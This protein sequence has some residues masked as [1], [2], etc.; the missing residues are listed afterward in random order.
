MTEEKP[1]TQ[2]DAEPPPPEKPPKPEAGWRTD[3]KQE[4]AAENE[5]KG[6]VR[7]TDESAHA[8]I[9]DQHQISRLEFVRR[10][11][12]AKPWV[13]RVFV[14]S[15]GEL[16]AF[17]R[18]KQPTTGE[19]LWGGFHSMYEVDLSLRRLTLEITLPSTGDA[20]VFRAEVDLQWR[21]E[22]PELVVR[23]GITDIRKVVI[24]LLLDRLRQV[25]RFRR[26]DEVEA[27]ENAANGSFGHKWLAD[28][29]GL[30]TQVL[31][32]L[33]MDKQKEHNVRL[34][35]EVEVFKT[36]IKGGDLDQFALQLAQNPQEVAPVVEALFNER[37]THRREV[38]SFITR[39]IESD[40]LDRW[41]IDDQVR[42]TL[43]W[44]QASIHRVLS[45]TD[46]ARQLSFD[47]SSP[48]PATNGSSS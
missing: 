29:Y 14:K 2:T 31:V 23:K 30:W 26:A 42:V 25:T 22:D 15:T 6:E 37:D 24:P 35:S 40:A 27:A 45:G 38:F 13:A 12:P 46:D 19:L 7:V 28:E 43:Q 16:A 47:G 3:A 17:S 20:F 48:R 5:D 11:L 36:L 32:R 18:D 10:R 21:V 34:K 33:R 41:Q 1:E 4:P 44:L 9:T 39:L 8:P